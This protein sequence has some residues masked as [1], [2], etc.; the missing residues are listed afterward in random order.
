M[1]EF[2][3]DDDDIVFADFDLDAAIAT[4]SCRHRRRRQCDLNISPEDTASSASSAAVMAPTPK[5]LFP[6]MDTRPNE[7][8]SVAY[9]DAYSNVNGDGDGDLTPSAAKKMRVVVGVGVAAAD[10]NNDI[11]N[12]DII[13][14]NGHGHDSRDNVPQQFKSET[15]S[16]LFTHFGHSNFRPG[17]LTVLHSILSKPVGR[18]TCVFWATGTGKSL[19]YQ[20]PPLQ[21]NTVALVVSPLISLMEDQVA[22]LNS[23]SGGAVATFLGSSQSDPDM[24]K[25]ALNG[26]Y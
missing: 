20:L 2:S 14:I 10:D 23:L 5:S 9:S 21:T 4:T 3:D 1:G 24:E 26:K 13:N 15:T 11:I 18:D 25:R 17:Q 16:A 19:C 7:N 6:M 22:K 8:L 12:N